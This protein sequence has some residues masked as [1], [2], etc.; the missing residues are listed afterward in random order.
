LTNKAAG[1]LQPFQMGVAVRG[2]MEAIIHST[3]QVVEE[4]QDQGEDDEDLLIL[5]VDHLLPFISLW[6]SNPSSRSLPKEFR[7]YELAVDVLL[8]DGPARGLILSTS[9]TTNNNP[10]SSVWCPSAVCAEYLYPALQ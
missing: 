10:N 2:G 4:A 3:R 5:R 7:G 8:E 6:P 9:A 1:F